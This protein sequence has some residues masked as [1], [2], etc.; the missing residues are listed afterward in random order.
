[1]NRLLADVIIGNTPINGNETLAQTYPNIGTLVGVILKNSLVII[2]II[3]L[4]L[5]I[6]GGLLFIINAGSSDSKKLA[7]AQ[8][9]LTD[10]VIGF[11]VVLLAFIVIQIIQTITGLNILNNTTL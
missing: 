8:T 7:Q 1:M 2:G 5:L 6:Y 3:L 4:G 11:V 10:A 9:I